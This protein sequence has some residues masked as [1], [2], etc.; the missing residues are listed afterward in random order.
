M[1]VV[2]GLLFATAFLS[3][4][5]VITTTIGNALP[6]VQQVVALEFGPATAFERRITFGEIKGRKSLPIAEVIAFPR[7]A[8]VEVDYLLAA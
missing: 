3:S 7:K 6:R 8:V 2:V 1:I 5:Y 4:I